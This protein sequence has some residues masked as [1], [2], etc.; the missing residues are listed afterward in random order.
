MPNGAIGSGEG[1]EQETEDWVAADA[2]P[3]PCEAQLGPPF[4]LLY[5]GY[6]HMMYD[7]VAC[8][9]LLRLLGRPS[10]VRVQGGAR[11]ACSHMI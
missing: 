5:S 6:I 10:G 1:G 3:L 7:T 4:A 2:P 9:L 8:L 11:L